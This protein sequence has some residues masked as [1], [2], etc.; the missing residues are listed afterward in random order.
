[1]EM[2]DFT[3]NLVLVVMSCVV[4]LVAGFTGLSLTRNMRQK[5]VLQQKV[6]I[7]LASVA[8]GGGIWSMHF[9]AM[10]GL[11]LPILFYYDAGI[12]LIS[13]LVAIL[14]VGAALIL[15]HF[16]KRTRALIIGAGALV[17]AGILAMYY[18][19]MA[20]LELCRAIYTPFGVIV[21]SIVAIGCCILAFWVAYEQRTNRNIFLGTVCFAVAVCSVHFL[22]MAGT[23]FVAEPRVVEF[24]P[25]IGNETLALGV[26][27]SSFVIFGAFLWVSTTYL[28]PADTPGKPADEQDNKEPA[29]IIETGLQIPCEKDGIKVFLA[30]A[31]VVMVRA[32]G[33]YTQVYTG[34]G[35]LFCVWPI[36]EA[37]KRLLPYGYL[38]THRSYES[39]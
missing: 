30:P 24:G 17:G 20:G 29:Q 18:I 36:A 19:G 6:S 21:S 31:D 5:T 35:R 26:I 34:Q 12:T 32:D 14:I 23:G 37:A 2:L 22:A 7:A 15:L 28:I 13:A 33:H 10:L 3:H 39:G 8:L 1:M 11:Q 25:V 27:L 38:Q 4:A 9:V 16:I